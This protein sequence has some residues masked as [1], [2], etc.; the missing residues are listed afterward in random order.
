[1]INPFADW[2][3]CLGSPEKLPPEKSTVHG[4]YSRVFK[5]RCIVGDGLPSGKFQI[6]DT[7]DNPHD[8]DRYEHARGV[9]LGRTEGIWIRISH[10]AG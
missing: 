8:A 10:G 5:R 6:C 7:E 3:D 1:M 9:K 2:K 4:G